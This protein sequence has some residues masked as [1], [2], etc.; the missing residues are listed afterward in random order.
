MLLNTLF[1]Q[2]YIFFIFVLVFLITL[3]IHESSHALAAYW[4]G[5]LTAK[6]AGRLTLNPFAHVD[7]LG[8]LT[9]V[10]VGFGWGKPVPFNPYNLKYNRWG[11]VFVAV[12]GPLSNFLL[13]IVFAFFYRIFVYLGD[14]NL[15]VVFLQLGAYLSFL[16]GFFNLIPIPPLDGSKALIALLQHERYRNIRVFLE[17]RGSILLLLLVFL[18]SIGGI[19]VFSFISQLSSVLFSVVVRLF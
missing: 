2:P 3:A 11:P 12:A 7:V 10:L 5:D 15:L 14:G 1:Q 4:L 19:G 16:L 8:F 13:G 9:L 6:R 18:D 17:T